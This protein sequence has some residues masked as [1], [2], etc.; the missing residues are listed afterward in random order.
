MANWAPWQLSEKERAARSGGACGGR[1]LGRR[2]AGAAP[3]RPRA[4]ASPSRPPARGPQHAARAESLA[5]E[6][7]VSS[8]SRDLN[9]PAPGAAR[10]GSQPH[11]GR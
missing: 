9:S 6:P 3:P 5:R 8:G 10:P 11:R 7:G 2:R 1:E 4:A